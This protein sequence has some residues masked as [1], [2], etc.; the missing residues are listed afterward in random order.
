[1][2][3]QLILLYTS[4]PNKLSEAVKNWKF[5]TLCNPSAQKIGSNSSLKRKVK[6]QVVP[7]NKKAKLYDPTKGYMLI[8]RHFEYSTDKICS[9]C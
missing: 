6:M 4:M 7:Q 3:H 8:D 1:M 9:M 5:R 2:L